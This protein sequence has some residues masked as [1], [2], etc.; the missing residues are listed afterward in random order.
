MDRIGG[1]AAKAARDSGDDPNAAALRA[2][3]VVI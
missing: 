1:N 3:G 2:L